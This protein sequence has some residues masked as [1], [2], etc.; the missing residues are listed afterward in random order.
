MKDAAAGGA[1]LRL[2]VPPEARFGKYVRERV[3]GFATS[4]G[5]GPDEVESFVTA[6]SEALANA[7]EHAHANEPIEVTCRFVDD[8]RLVATVVDHG[9][10]FETR[11]RTPKLPNPLAERGR[12]LPLMRSFSDTFA[13]RSTPGK[14]TAVTLARFVGRRDSGEGRTRARP[15]R[16]PNAH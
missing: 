5:V 15:G 3:A 7:V 8:E 12:G 16:S 2:L 9:I 11:Q 1:S 4:F 13:V 6:V 14:G 10:G